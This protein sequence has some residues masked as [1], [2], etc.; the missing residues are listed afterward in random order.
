VLARLPPRPLIGDLL[1]HSLQVLLLLTLIVASA[2]MAGALATRI[3]QPSVFGEILAGLLLGPTVLNVLG[4]PIFVSPEGADAA[5]L[6]PLVRDLAQIGVLLLMFVAGLETDLVLM[7]HVGRVAFWSAFGGVVLP[8]AGGAA[9]AVVFG[10]PLYWE[11]IFIGAILTATSVSISAQTLLEIGALRSREGSTILGAAVIDDVMGII[12]LSLVVALAKAAGQG[13]DWLQLA[14]VVLRVTLFFVGAIAARR[15]LGPVLRWSSGLGVSQ[16]VL[17]AALVLMF[18]YA[19]A[20]EYVG[21]VAAIT[22]AYLAGVLIAQTE[23]K[24]DVDAG[25]HPL[26]YSMFV[27]LFFISIGLEANGRELG[28]RAMFTVVLVLVAIVAKAIGCGVFARLFGFSTRE[29]VR[30]G[31]GMISRGEVGLIVAG[32]GLANGLITSEVFSASV[33]MVLVTTMVT[34]PMMRLVFPRHAFVPASV[35]ETIAAVPGNDGEGA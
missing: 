14:L 10:L 17:A 35:E 29:S 3:H 16:A 30:V 18:L 28:P 23:F 1:T 26:T 8:M 15:L 27:P 34:P 6:L 7:R 21:A 33:I 31:I 32:Y 13:F 22:G 20:A 5:P 19:W 12:V 11:G 4:W 24:K 9:T 2:K 25:I